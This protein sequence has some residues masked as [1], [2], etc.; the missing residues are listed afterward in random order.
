MTVSQKTRTITISVRF[1][2][3]ED[4]QYECKCAKLRA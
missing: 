3:F 2:E 1:Y 4:R